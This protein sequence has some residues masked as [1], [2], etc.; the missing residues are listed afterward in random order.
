[1]HKSMLIMLGLAGLV[2]GSAQAGMRPPPAFDPA[3]E[4]STIDAGGGE[5][6]SGG[7]FT[8]TGSIGQP[9]AQRYSGGLTYSVTGGFWEGGAVTTPCPSDINDDGVSDLEDFFLFFNFFDQTD[10]G[11]DFNHD[12][13]MDL[14]DFFAFFNAFDQPC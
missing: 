13:V 4:W 14:E 7:T 10:F 1:M 12:G 5:V 3:I 11:G 6:S 8:L 9:D 2:S